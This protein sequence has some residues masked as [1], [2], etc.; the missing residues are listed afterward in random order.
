MPRAQASSA[1][2]SLPPGCRKSKEKTTMRP[3]QLQ[4]RL[5]L[6][7]AALL[8]AA[9]GG[10][11]HDPAPDPMAEYRN[12]ALVWSACDPSIFGVD[13]PSWFEDLGER[14]R[15]A[16]VR[17]PIDYNNPANGGLTVALS[18]VAAADA[19]R[20]IGALMLNPGGPGGD[21][22][23]MPPYLAS[24]LLLANRELPTGELLNDFQARFDLVGFS[25]RGTGAS[26]QLGC[27]SNEWRRPH[28]YPLADRS[29]ATLD[30]MLYNAWLEAH[31]CLKNPLT[32]YINTEQTVEDMELI[33]HLL[34]Q[35][36]LHYL[37][38]SY[39]TWLGSWY[40]ARHPERVGRFVLD[41]AMDFTAD[42]SR[43]SDTHVMGKQRVFNDVLAVRIAQYHE[44]FDLG[45]NAQAISQQF[46]SFP[47]T[48][49]N[50]IGLD[51]SLNHRDS[52]NSS[53]VS[54]V[55][56]I[57]LAEALYQLPH[58][59]LPDVAE[60]LNAQQLSPWSP[61]DAAIR[62]EALALAE[63]YFRRVENIQPQSIH[64]NGSQ[65]TFRAVV[66]ND[67]AFDT[68]PQ[69][70]IEHGNRFAADYPLAGGMLT[71]QPCAFWGGPVV[72]KPEP[73][74]TAKAG[75]MLIVQGELDPATIAEGAL[76]TH[77]AMPNTSLLMVNGEI[78][79]GIFPYDTDCV[80]K[81]ILRYLLEGEQPPQRT[82]CEAL[83]F[84]DF[85][86]EYEEYGED[87]AP[88]AAQRAPS[89]ERPALYRDP[90]RAR[91]LRER[92]HEMVQGVRW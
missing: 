84:T 56:A 80:A 64:L 15:C 54:Y 29:P 82:D 24:L 11:S 57:H 71:F 22:L 70:W 19:G 17:V 43:N 73:A 50:M 55:A 51:L 8:L 65:A 62:D 90:E 34:G 9:C 69:Y 86:D 78:T 91:I 12:Q 66:C 42:F 40:A 58:A 35:E 20:R 79:H 77:H 85:Y 92:L 52:L 13:M 2:G 59:T 61:A 7:A 27:E 44:I 25:P 5:S 81:P 3:S 60:F 32:P 37:G 72:N 74:L 88:M 28:P 89:T 26:T 23:N 53:L 10:D 47:E 45:T 46:L 4:R 83:P 38:Y 30:A 16:D 18:K 87:E 39:G 36:Q 6:V 33:R 31:T 49:Q 75:P 21:G 67:P 1:P 41:S 63:G 68:D 14:L 48:L 76:N